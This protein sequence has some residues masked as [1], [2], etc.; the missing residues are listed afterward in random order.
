MVTLRILTRK[1]RLGFGPYG[2]ETIDLLLNRK[3]HRYLRSVYYTYEA[4]SF[5]DDILD[6]IGIIWRIDKPG[7]DTSLI[8]KTNAAKEAKRVG[9]IKGLEQGSAEWK[10][11][12]GQRSRMN[13]DKRHAERRKR[14][15]TRHKEHLTKGEMQAANHGHIYISVKE[16]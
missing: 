15:Q 2:N 4:I 8:E 9:H 16:D 13:A 7:S 6:E 12:M 1:S 5:Q 14:A 3:M 10:Q 11:A